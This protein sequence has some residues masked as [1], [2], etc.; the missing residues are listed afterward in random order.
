MIPPEL[1]LGHAGSSSRR[2]PAVPPGERRRGPARSIVWVSCAAGTAKPMGL[3]PV[4]GAGRPPIAAAS[5]I[6]IEAG[7]AGC[8]ALADADV[9]DRDSLWRPSIRFHLGDRHLSSRLDLA[10]R[11]RKD[12]QRLVATDRTDEP[13]T[14]ES[15]D[16]L[17]ETVVGKSV[18]CGTANC[19]TRIRCSPA[20]ASSGPRSVR[21][22]RGKSSR[23][24]DA[25]AIFSRSPARRG[26]AFAA[27]CCAAS[28]GSTTS[29]RW[30]PGTAR[31]RIRSRS[32]ARR[33][34]YVMI[35]TTDGERDGR[36]TGRLRQNWR[37]KRPRSIRP[38]RRGRF[39]SAICLRSRSA[40]LSGNL[41][42]IAF[43]VLA[44]GLLSLVP[45]L[46]TNVL[47]NSVIPRNETR[48]ADVLRARACRH[49]DLR[50]PAS[51][52]CRGWRC[53][54]SKASIDWKL[55]AA[56]DRPAAQAAGI[57]VSR[58]YRRR[59]C[60]PLDGHR[61]GAAG[62]HGTRAARL[63]GRPVLPGSASA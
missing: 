2:R 45:P 31:T 62:L 14:L 53:S 56:R 55:Q 15:L 42:R 52:P 17:A 48:P 50:S 1:E 6:W 40:G 4:I 34:R 51:R 7:E 32:S 63:D 41:V 27:L 49:G 25:S 23:N 28:G 44:I 16:R 30:W 58:I 57:A 60:R 18:P 43:L 37:R 36:S 20:A 59:F 46:I 54:G 19:T 5:G 47:I 8:S 29:D 61:R 9:P 39:G 38:C 33:R 11:G 12:R 21:H 13:Q 26:C 3:D 22:L 24:A 35:D 10:R